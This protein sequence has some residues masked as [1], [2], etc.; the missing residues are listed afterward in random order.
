MLLMYPETGSAAGQGD[1]MEDLPHF[2]VF[3]LAR[4]RG[5]GAVQLAR[6]EIVGSMEYSGFL[7]METIVSMEIPF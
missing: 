3:H 6:Q 2:R 7:P 1:S 5:L 4:G